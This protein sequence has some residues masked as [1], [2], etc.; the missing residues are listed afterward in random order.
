MGW[1]CRLNQ[2][3]ARGVRVIAELKVIDVGD[4]RHESLRAC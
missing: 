2:M 4:D 1:T 3:E